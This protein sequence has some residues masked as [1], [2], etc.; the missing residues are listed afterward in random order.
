MAAPQ[1]GYIKIVRFAEST[2]KEVKDALKALKKQGMKRLIID[3]QGNGGGYMNA[4]VGVA[5]LFL[6]K[7]D[8]IVYTKGIRVAPSY[9]DAVVTGLIAILKL[10]LWLTSHRLRPV[11][12]FQVL[13]RTTTVEWSSDA[14]RSAKVWCN[15][16]SRF[17]MAL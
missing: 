1:T 11:R 5:Q 14:V 6:D 15:A 4:A 7:D 16:R 13:Y 3:L 10:S 8:G 17:P 2:E 12:S 9:F